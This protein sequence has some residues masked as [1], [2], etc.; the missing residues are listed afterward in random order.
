V[1]LT[2]Y[3]D[4]TATARF[5]LNMRCAS[6]GYLTGFSDIEARWRATRWWRR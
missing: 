6:D 4:V 2:A 1:F 3:Y 5:A